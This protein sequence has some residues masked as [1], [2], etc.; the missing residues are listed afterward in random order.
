MDNLKLWISQSKFSVPNCKLCMFILLL[1]SKC[2]LSVTQNIMWHFEDYLFVKQIVGKVQNEIFIG[3]FF[4]I[5]IHVI[6][7]TLIKLIVLI[8]VIKH[9]CQE[10]L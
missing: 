4:I 3:V 7:R 2:K 8:A 10:L 5:C 6:V 9:F 1:I